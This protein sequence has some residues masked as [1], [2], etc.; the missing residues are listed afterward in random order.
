MQGH[1]SSKVTDENFKISSPILQTLTPKFHSNSV[2][3]LCKERYQWIASKMHGLVTLQN[4]RCKNRPSQFARISVSLTDSESPK[5][6]KYFRRLED[7]Q[8][9]CR[10]VVAPN[11]IAANSIAEWQPRAVAKQGHS[12]NIWHMANGNELYLWILHCWAQNGA[13]TYFRITWKIPNL[14]KNLFKF[15]RTGTTWILAKCYGLFCRCELLCAKGPCITEPM[16]WSHPSHR[17]GTELLW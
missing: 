12:M 3:A 11:S 15:K 17:A 14:F 6:I 13:T 1:C 2:S 7:C 5:F 10:F 4:R 16:H 8:F 9:F